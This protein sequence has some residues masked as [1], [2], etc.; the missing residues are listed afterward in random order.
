[1]ASNKLGRDAERDNKES[2]DKWVGIYIGIV[3]VVLAVCAM[4][5]GNA[6]KDSTRYNIEA[7]NGWL[8]GR[9]GSVSLLRLAVAE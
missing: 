7:A 8:Q 5:G 6:T 1:M 9:G 3:A 4:G 2:R